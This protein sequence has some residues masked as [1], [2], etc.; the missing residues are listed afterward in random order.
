MILESVSS[1]NID[2][3]GYDNTTRQLVVEIKGGKQYR[4]DG[5]PE[6]V[7]SSFKAAPSKG[8]YFSASIKGKY[9]Y[10]KL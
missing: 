6:N 9:P 10:T 7:Y 1:T 3:I 5:V 8:K 2:K 4:Y